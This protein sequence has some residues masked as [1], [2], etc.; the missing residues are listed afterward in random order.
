M[1]SDP[2]FW[3]Y[4]VIAVTL[5]GISKGGFGGGLGVVG[6]PLL[7]MTTSPATAAA[8]L[9]PILIVMDFTGLHGWRGRW[10]REQ[11]GRLIPAAL[12]GIVI[13]ALSFHLFSDDGIRILI[14]IIGI[15]FGLSWWIRQLGLSSG[16]ASNLPGPWHTR[17]WACV[18]GFTSF[19]VH[20][21]G[22]PLAVALLPQRLPPD[23]YAATTVVFFTWVN[24]AKV[25]PY[26]WL[27]QFSFN[28][29]VT[30]A[31]LAPLGILAVRLGISIN[32]MISE[33]WFYRFCYLFLL[34]IS[35]RLIYI[36]LTNVFG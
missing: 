4:A 25:I 20:A 2:I 18:S 26:Y 33:S 11:L 12:I 36:G 27:D 19:G 32:S 22:P 3:V 23:R 14:G 15:G 31:V 8:I 6:V 21:G 34:V 30:A 13:G 1:S 5:V 28:V 29:L 35:G 17:C 24:L 16:V 10:D 7:A 9:L